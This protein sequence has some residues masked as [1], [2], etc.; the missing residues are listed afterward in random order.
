M[1]E[2]GEKGWILVHC[3]SILEH[4]YAAIAAEKSKV[5][6]ATER[7]SDK[8]PSNYLLKMIVVIHIKNNNGPK[9]VYSKINESLIQN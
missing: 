1:R 9:K 2:A 5:S 3:S 8:Q 7:E 4:N 6:E